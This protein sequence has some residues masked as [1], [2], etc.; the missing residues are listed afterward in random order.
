MKNLILAG[1]SLLGALIFLTNPAL[2]R[3]RVKG[4]FK[5]AD[6]DRDHRISRIEWNRRG[7]FDR[8]DSNNDGL[9][10]LKEVRAMYAGQNDKS[11]RWP[12]QGMTA[13]PPEFDQ[14]VRQDSVHRDALDEKTLCGIGRMRKCS[15]SD[16]VKLGMLAT[17]MGPRFPTGAKCLGIDDYWALDYSFKRN[18]TSYHG[19]IDMPAGWGTPIIA[20]ADGSVVAIYQGDKSARGIELVLRHSPKDTGLPFWTYT[21][22]AHLDRTPDLKIAQ[23][24]YRGQI[25]GPTG[26]SGVSGKKG[27]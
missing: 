1:F 12:P 13:S 11:Y 9:L 26:N 24:V 15:I 27:Q 22:Y 7:N 5:R 21:Q 2:A 4:D 20:A 6:T 25:L 19:G 3:D 23:R 17:G 18:R 10:S 16:A 8:L 14:S